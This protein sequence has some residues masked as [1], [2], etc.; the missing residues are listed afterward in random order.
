[1]GSGVSASLVLGSQMS[2]IVFI[3]LWGETWGF[4]L[5]RQGLYQTS[6]QPFWV[7][8]WSFETKSHTS[9]VQDSACVYLSGLGLHVCVTTAVFFMVWLLV[10]GGFL[11]GCMAVLYQLSCLPTPSSFPDW[12]WQSLPGIQPRRPGSY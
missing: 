4:M 8:F 1:M 7:F 6:P 5:A 2:T 10:M 9:S 3:R 11:S 12:P